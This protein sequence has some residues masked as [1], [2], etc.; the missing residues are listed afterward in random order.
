MFDEL[1]E[2][3][4]P[5]DIADSLR[6]LAG[7]TGNA[8]V[9]ALFAYAQDM[10]M[11]PEEMERLRLRRHVFL[12]RFGRQSM[13]QWEDVEGRTVRRYTELLAEMLREENELAT[14][15]AGRLRSQE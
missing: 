9:D 11:Q 6:C 1:G 8:T 3:R 4:T 13:L 7:V 10:A 15:A 2:Q 5:Q 12:A 14:Q